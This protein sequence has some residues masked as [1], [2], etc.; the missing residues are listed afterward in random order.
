MGGH[1]GTSASGGVVGCGGADGGSD[2]RAQQG[3]TTYGARA[4]VLHAAIDAGIAR[5]ALTAAVGLVGKAR[6]WFESGV[7]RPTIRC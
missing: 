3:P 4:Q 6:P 5:G 7:E 2:G 1:G